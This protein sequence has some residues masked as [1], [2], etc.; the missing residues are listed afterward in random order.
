MRDAD[1]A[2]NWVGR[3]SA[4]D[5]QGRDAPFEEGSVDASPGDPLGFGQVAAA[6]DG[7]IHFPS[8]KQQIWLAEQVTPPQIAGGGVGSGQSLAAR[9][10]STQFPVLRQ[11][12]CPCGQSVM[13]QTPS[14]PSRAIGRPF[15]S[16]PV[17]PLP[18]GPL[19]D[20]PLPDASPGPIGL[21][22]QAP[23]N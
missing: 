13:P 19:L 9:P 21:R 6:V 22:P 8:S 2:Q 3:Q 18:L 11:H 7:S 17:P 14:S 23:R 5:P 12:C 15:A 20:P 10:G 16:P 1:V 4:L